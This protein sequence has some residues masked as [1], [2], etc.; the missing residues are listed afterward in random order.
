MPTHP[1]PGTQISSSINIYLCIM[2]VS[3]LSFSLFL[4]FFPSSLLH[5]FQ[6]VFSYHFFDSRRKTF[7]RLFSPSLLPTLVPG[8]LLAHLLLMQIRSQLLKLRNDT[9][10]PGVCPKRLIDMLTVSFEIHE[11]NKSV[12][13]LSACMIHVLLSCF[14]GTLESA[15]AC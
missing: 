5:S 4:D 7:D 14:L 10:L 2:Q 13:I 8:K 3:C 15:S 11:N 9:S 6:F 12:L 1:L